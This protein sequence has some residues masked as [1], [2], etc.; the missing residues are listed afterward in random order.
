MSKN[1][2][3][4]IPTPGGANNS[5]YLREMMGIMPPAPATCWATRHTESKTA[6]PYGTA[7]AGP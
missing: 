4:P 6:A 7:D 1:K 5:P 2:N 3:K